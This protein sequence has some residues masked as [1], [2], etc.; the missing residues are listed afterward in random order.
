MMGWNGGMG[1]GWGGWILLCVLVLL[2]VAVVIWGLTALLRPQRP[3]EQGALSQA[4]RSGASRTLPEDIL[5]ERFARG[6]ID[7][8]E[9]ERRRSHLIP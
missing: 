6:E 9:Y 5:A 8:D 3:S 1:W 2:L 7:E 4:V